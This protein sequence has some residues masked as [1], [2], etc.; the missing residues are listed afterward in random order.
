MLDVNTDTLRER[1]LEARKRLLRISSAANSVHIGSSLSMIEIL[2]VL[3]GK[4]L[5]VTPNNINLSNRDK[6]ILSKGHAGLGLYIIL[7]QFGF[8]KDVELSAYAKDGTKLAVH[9]VLNSAPGIEATSGSLGHGLPITLGMAI[10]GRRNG[11]NSRYV[12]L[13]SDGECDEGSNWEAIMFAGHLGL[14]NLLVILDYNKIQSFGTT[15]EVLELE[16]FKDK[17]EAN[18]WSVKEVDGHDL[19]QLTSVL[20]SFPFETNKPS[21]IIA[22]TVKGKGVPHLE[23]TLESHYRSIKSEELDEVLATVY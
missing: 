5:R 23:N 7:A 17:W 20:N 22:H 1:S 21:V 13:M 12:V 14:D 10:A 19:D 18:R 2:E 3:Y 11:W 15:S 4:F 8:I 16:P 6:F 9:P